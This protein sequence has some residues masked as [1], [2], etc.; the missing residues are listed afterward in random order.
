MKVKPNETANNIK[1]AVILRK[2]NLLN[3]DAISVYKRD[4]KYGSDVITMKSNDDPQK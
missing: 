4:Y 3:N 1:F 2:L